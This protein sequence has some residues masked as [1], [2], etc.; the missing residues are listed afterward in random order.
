MKTIRNDRWMSVGVSWWLGLGLLLQGGITLGAVETPIPPMIAPS[1]ASDLVTINV[2]NG[3]IAQVLNAFSRQ[4]G[5]SIVIGAEVTGNV[6][7]RL[8]DKRWQ[9][10]LDVIL[11]PYGFDYYMV[12]DTIIICGKDKVPKQAVGTNGVWATAPGATQGPPPEPLVVKAFALKYLDA[13]DLEDLVKSQ[14]SPAGRIG[15][16]VSRSQTWQDQQVFQGNLNTTSSESLGRLKRLQEEPGQV[17]GKMLVVVDTQKIIDRIQS[18]ITLVD[19]APSQV[20]IEA[21][22]VE[23]R[24]DFMRDVGVEWGTGLNGA[25]VPGVKTIGTSGAGS[26][27]AA[28]AQQISGTVKPAGFQSGSGLSATRPF[29]GGMSLAFQKLTDLQLEVILHLMEEDSSYKMLSS[30]RVLTMNNQD[31]V[32]IVGQKLPIIKSDSSGGVGTTTISTSLERYEDVGIK[33]KVMPQVC[34]DNSINLIVHPSVRELLGYQSGKVGTASGDN[35]GVSL[36]EYP[37]I[38]TRE[39]ETHV[40]IRSG[41]T[42]VI[43]GMLRDKKTTTTIKVPFL[44]SIPLVGLLFRR[45]MIVTEKFELMIFLTARVMDPNDQV[46]VKAPEVSRLIP[47]E[48]VAADVKM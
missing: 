13:S 31:A 12:G 26:V 24:A 46:S 42:V 17:R 15:K 23:I 14:I 9:D 44:G 32:I 10:A 34:E 29:D 27:F 19:K 3:P 7:L 45:D 41:Q 47:E 16:L 21:R 38:A 8:T 20:L 6:T 22:F 33:L 43:G 25:T 1:A 4:T 40:M 5:R 39:A 37:V 18:I 36:T 11:K 35:A 2:D 28:G 30:P 48:K